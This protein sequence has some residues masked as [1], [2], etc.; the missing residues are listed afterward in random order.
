MNDQNDIHAFKITAGADPLFSTV[1]GDKRSR[2]QDTAISAEAMLPGGDLLHL[3]L[4]PRRPSNRRAEDR[5]VAGRNEV[6]GAA[7]EN[8]ADKPP[9][10]GIP[11]S[12]FTGVGGAVVVVDSGDGGAGASPV[13]PHNSTSAAPSTAPR[14]TGPFR[15]FPRSP[16]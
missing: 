10:G 5:V 9:L 7:H 1:K 12:P 13:H 4:E 3:G 15:V 16:W 14:I 6:D 11:V 2:I 8:R